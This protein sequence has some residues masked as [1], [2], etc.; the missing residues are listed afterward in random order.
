MPERVTVH[1]SKGLFVRQPKVT[2]VEV[3]LGDN[4]YRLDVANGRLQASVALVVRGIALNTRSIDP[5]TWFAQ[6]NE[7]TRK[8]SEH[9]KA[10]SGLLS[11]FMAS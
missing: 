10:L 11:G 2:G 4:R 1:E 6:L 3:E 7:E 8:A 9:A 5:A